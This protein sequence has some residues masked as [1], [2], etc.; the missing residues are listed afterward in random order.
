M[1]QNNKE[2]HD[3]RPLPLYFLLLYVHIFIYLSTTT[4]TSTT[5][6]CAS[7]VER[8]S[9]THF[10]FHPTSPYTQVSQV[11]HRHRVAHAH[12][13]APTSACSQGTR[14]IQNLLPISSLSLCL[15]IAFHTKYICIHFIAIYL[16]L[17]S[18]LLI[19]TSKI[20]TH[21]TKDFLSLPFLL[22]HVYRHCSLGYTYSFLS[23]FLFFK[24][25]S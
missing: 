22:Q 21:S 24:S 11:S 13:L 16:L 5:A 18:S 19:N 23:S 4:P 7:R 25:S 1:E 12:A 6:G 17:L 20:L 8:S 14:N 2:Q 9:N 3:R 10:H 15:H